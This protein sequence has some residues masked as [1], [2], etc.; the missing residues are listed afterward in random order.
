MA[1]L[2][3]A[4]ALLFALAAACGNDSHPMP[5]A[6]VGAPCRT[7]YDCAGLYCV[8]PSGGTC[9]LACRGD[10]DCGPGASCKSENRHGT[11]G[12][13]DVCIPN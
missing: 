10:L 11:G 3:I 12:K 5:G 6:F 4:A 13:I 7:D 9:Q 1:K 8:D 2:P